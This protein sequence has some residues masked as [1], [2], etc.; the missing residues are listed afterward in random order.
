MRRSTL[1]LALLT[2]LM[3]G[4]AAVAQTSAL[5]GKV[6]DMNG[7]PVQGAEVSAAATAFPDRV[8]KGAS[9]KKGSFYI[10]GL[11]FAAQAPD[12]KISIKAEGWV[13]VSLKIVARDGSKTMYFSDDA[14]LSAANP[15]TTFKMRPFSEIRLEYT[16]RPGDAAAE[17]NPIPAG[18]G[19]RGRS[20]RRGCR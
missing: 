2:T 16:M 5:I 13:P 19:P 9:D 15:S 11:L 12:W 4:T 3:V 18:P 14:K 6:A 1:P 20:G 7:K 17:A 10:D 8:A